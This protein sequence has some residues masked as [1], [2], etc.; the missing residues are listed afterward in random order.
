MSQIKI[1]YVTNRSRTKIFMAMKK[2]Y[3]EFDLI[4]NDLK[5]LSKADMQKHKND[6]FCNA[7]HPV[8][9]KAG[10]E[11]VYHFAHQ[12]GVNCDCRGG[13][14][15]IHKLAKIIMKKYLSTI[16][17]N[18]N[19]VCKWCRY[20]L[21]T[22]TLHKELPENINIEYPLS[23]GGRADIAVVKNNVV[24]YVIEIYNTSVT[25]NEDRNEYTW[26]EIN[27][28]DVI[29]EWKN[30]DTMILQEIC[31]KNRKKFE[32][33]RCLSIKLDNPIKGCSTLEQII[34]FLKSI[35]DINMD[36]LEIDI[37]LDFP[38]CQESLIYTNLLL[39]RRKTNE[40][41]LLL[42]NDF[43]CIVQSDDDKEYYDTNI[44]PNISESLHNMITFC[45]I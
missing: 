34:E 29:N 9:I 4:S 5:N 18:I 27:A 37:P 38:K 11:K 6:I 2:S 41:L 24:S 16:N 45:K 19:N 32:C 22:E 20:I 30:S 3:C 40:L 31:F 14:D 43:K 39:E 1:P 10:N 35:E 33:D 26:Y 12:S 23:N 21:K 8:I 28:Q 42:R 7:K 25:K 15:D 36:P 13:E 17:V 44:K